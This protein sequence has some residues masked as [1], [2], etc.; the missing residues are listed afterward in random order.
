M[1]FP[2]STVDHNSYSVGQGGL[3]L[4]F[5]NVLPEKHCLLTLIF[6]LEMSFSG[7]TVGH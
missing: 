6:S 4:I 2:G 3:T 7:S 5:R 1:S